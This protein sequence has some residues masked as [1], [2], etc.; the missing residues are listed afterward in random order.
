MLIEMLQCK[1][2]GLTCTQTDLRYPGSVTVAEDLIQLA[3]WLPGQ[4]V[5]VVNVNTGGR[6][7]TYLIKGE[8]GSGVVC[9]NGAAARL[10]AVGDILLLMSYV[11]LDA[12]E[13]SC[14]EPKI[15]RVDAQNRALWSVPELHPLA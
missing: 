14:F 2:H 7:E 1:I 3:G 6:F 9:L 4:K 8:R 10:A 12:N 5:Q 15:I 11:Y 13:A